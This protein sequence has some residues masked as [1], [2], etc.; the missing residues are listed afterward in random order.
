MAQLHCKMWPV[1]PSP[2][3]YTA[4]IFFS[5]CRCFMTD[6]KVFMILHQ[7][8]RADDEILKSA[9]SCLV[10]SMSK[11]RSKL[12]PMPWFCFLSLCASSSGEVGWLLKFCQVD[13]WREFLSFIDS[14]VI[15][16]CFIATSYQLDFHSKANSLYTRVFQVAI[17][18]FKSQWNSK[19]SF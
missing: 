11:N 12:K 4:G 9:E 7:P 10:F 8:L 16:V 14:K 18:W 1:A 6:P 15:Q 3:F 5:L 2:L 13:A 17:Y 19:D